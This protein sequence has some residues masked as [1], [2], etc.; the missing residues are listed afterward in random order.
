MSEVDDRGAALAE[1]MRHVIATEQRTAFAWAKEAGVA[2]TTI[3]RFLSG[4][5]QS[6]PSTRTIAKLASCTAIAPPIGGEAITGNI[7]S[8][9]DLARV[10]AEV[11][12]QLLDAG[13]ILSPERRAHIYA[14]AYERVIL[15]KSSA[16]LRKYA[17]GLIA[18]ARAIAG[19]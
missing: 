1:W 2:Q 11:D 5:S 12:G 7:I 13:L 10:V 19:I 18:F 15:E 3:T 17:A 16:R 4:A 8:A 6:L 9:P 14:A